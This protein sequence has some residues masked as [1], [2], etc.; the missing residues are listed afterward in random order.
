MDIIEGI[1]KAVNLVAKA[2]NLADELNNLKM[3]EVIVELKSDLIDLKEQILA[4]REE[5]LQLKEEAKKRSEAPTLTI[6]E[7]KYY[8]AEGD[9]PFCTGCYDSRKEMIRLTALNTAFRG[10]GNWR[11]PVCRNKVI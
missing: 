6:K 5:N 9:G 1:G 2:K 10:I 7:G 11:C 8:C 3:K 4:L